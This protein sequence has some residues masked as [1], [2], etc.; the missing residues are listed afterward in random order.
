M[1]Y[2]INRNLVYEKKRIEDFN[3]NSDN[4]DEDY[5]PEDKID[6]SKYNYLYTGNKNEGLYDDN[7]DDYENN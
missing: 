1:D 6:L 7:S 4:D 2:P 3:T 5:L